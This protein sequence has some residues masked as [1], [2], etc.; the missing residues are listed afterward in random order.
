MNRN[1]RKMLYVIV[2]NPFLGNFL[3]NFE[4]ENISSYL[5][6]PELA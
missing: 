6:T 5:R 2:F 3:L 1:N 4:K